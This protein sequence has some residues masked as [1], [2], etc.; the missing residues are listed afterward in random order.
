MGGR[1]GQEVKDFFFLK[2]RQ[3]SEGHVRSRGKRER[4]R[5]GRLNTVE[6]GGRERRSAP[7][8]H[9]WKIKI[10]PA[11]RPTFLSACCS[12]VLFFASLFLAPVPGKQIAVLQI[13]C[14]DRS[15]P[16]RAA[17]TGGSSL[18]PPR[19]FSLTPDAERRCSYILILLHVHQINVHRF[20][21][22]RIRDARMEKT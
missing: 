4:E 22:A 18:L 21:L 12:G 15:K 10:H 3:V 7:R 17:N 13:K 8:T 16:N 2:R 6:T 20:A 14:D 11:A 1:V 5:S 19:I 9:S